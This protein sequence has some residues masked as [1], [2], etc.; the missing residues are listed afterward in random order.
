MPDEQKPKSDVASGTEIYECLVCNGRQKELRS[1][2]KASKVSCR[3]CGGRAYPVEEQVEGSTKVRYCR[4]CGTKLRSGNGG[5][6][7]SLCGDRR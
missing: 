6:R 5:I 1:A 4:D 3:S 2:R 7:C